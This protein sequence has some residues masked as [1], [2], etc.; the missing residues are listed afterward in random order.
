MLVQSNIET[1]DIGLSVVPQPLASELPHRL[2]PQRPAQW[3]ELEAFVLYRFHRSG[4]REI[5][6]NYLQASVMYFV[7][8]RTVTA[9]PEGRFHKA[10]I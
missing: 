6:L 2:G 4:A 9:V 1:G 3:G 5:Q 8:I 7:F 10:N